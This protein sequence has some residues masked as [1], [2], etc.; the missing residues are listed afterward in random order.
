M[1]EVKSLETASVYAVQSTGRERLF[2]KQ[3][4]KIM[5]VIRVVPVFI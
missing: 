4:Q 2:C 1:G 3:A 5:K